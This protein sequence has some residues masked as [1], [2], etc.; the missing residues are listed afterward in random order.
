[1]NPGPAQGPLFAPL[2]QLEAGSQ[3]PQKTRAAKP[4]P[5]FGL[6]IVAVPG[7]LSRRN[8]IL[9]PVLQHNRV[10]SPHHP[11]CPRSPVMG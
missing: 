11:S 10:L 9:H 8:I 4:R 1:M 3:G 5:T 6:S 7:S 2:Q